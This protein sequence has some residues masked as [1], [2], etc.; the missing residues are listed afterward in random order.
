VVLDSLP[1]NPSGKVDR[2]AL[3][4]PVLGSGEAYVAPRTAVEEGVA[5]IW[6]EVLRVEKVGVEDNFFS[7]GGHSLL[8]TRIVSRIRQTFGVDL[9]L[10]ELFESP[11]V[12]SVA[13]CIEA[14]RWSRG[15]TAQRLVGEE[16]EELEL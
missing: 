13:E 3:P 5:S 15:P 16:R 6:S 9:P 7:L 8:A 2:S 12:A 1:L 14:A 4:A 10:R 11:T